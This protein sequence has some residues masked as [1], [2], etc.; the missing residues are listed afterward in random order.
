MK[1]AVS[2]LVFAVVVLLAPSAMS[3][4]QTKSD[5]E[6]TRAEIQADRKAIVADNLPLTEDQATAFWPIYREYRG[7][8]DKIGDRV[9]KLITD[10]ATNFDSLS[11]EKAD[12]LLKEFLAVQKDVV[13]VKEK[14][15]PRFVKVLP[16]KTVLRFYQI[17]NKLD[18]IVS[19]GIV[20]QV[21]LTK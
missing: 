7:E 1:K 3:W 19:L 17:E 11:D 5:V 8:M 4:A 14:F 18:T 10:Y 16:A 20:A 13:K 12:A 2:I 21:P 6:V 9:V 15:Q